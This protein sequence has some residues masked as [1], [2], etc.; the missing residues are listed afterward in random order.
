MKCEQ[1]RLCDQ[2]R[3]IIIVIKV[4]LGEDVM[5]NELKDSQR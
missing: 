1:S 2:P 4:Q 5:I 3:E